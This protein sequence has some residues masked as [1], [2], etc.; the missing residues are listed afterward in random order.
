MKTYSV[1]ECKEIIE[2]MQSNLKIKNEVQNE[3]HIFFIFFLYIYILELKFKKMF[4]L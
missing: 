3:D 4:F 2:A 1:R